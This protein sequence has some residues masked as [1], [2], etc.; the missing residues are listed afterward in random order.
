[1]RQ[2]HV[3]G[4]RQRWDQRQVLVDESEPERLGFVGAHRQG[5]VGAEQPH[6]SAWLGRVKP[7]QDLDQRRFAR[8]VGP[9]EAVDL[10]AAHRQIDA[11]QR[12]FAA[13]AFRQVLDDQCVPGRCAGRK[14]RG[15][16]GWVH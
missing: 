9:K 6:G 15:R 16:N 2:A 10:A 4:Q 5:Q 8:A 14:S 11:V 13:E 3:L 7:G 1:M 12:Q